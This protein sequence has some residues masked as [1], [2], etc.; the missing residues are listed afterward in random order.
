MPKQN[1]SGGK[2]KL[3]SISKQGDRYLR[4]VY[5]W[6]ARRDPLRQNPWYRPSALAYGTAGATTDQGRRNRACQQARQ[7]D[8]GDDGQERTLQGTG[9]AHGVNE[10]APDTAGVT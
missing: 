4:T 8:V 10:I 1:A 9:R 2:D 3:G 6:S 5:G 7:D